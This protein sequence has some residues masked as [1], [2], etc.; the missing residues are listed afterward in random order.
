MST[1]LPFESAA[2]VLH[3]D[4]NVAVARQ[5]LKAGTVLESAPGG[6]E[7]TL[8]APVDPGHRFGIA[9]IHQGDF[10]RQYGQPIGTSQGIAPGDR[11]DH[12]NMSDEVPIVRDLPDNLS[13]LGPTPPPEGERLTFDGFVRPDSRTGTRNWVLVV[14]TSMCASHE[15]QQIATLGEF[16]HWSE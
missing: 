3:G 15:A 11:V 1:R 16:Q 2:V 4:D 9:A 6:L 8:T 10:V 13:N 7:L 14:P 5:S 12:G